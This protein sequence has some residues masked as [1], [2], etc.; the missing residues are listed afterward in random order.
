MV[1]VPAVPG[2]VAQRRPVLE[3]GLP[4]LL[5]SGEG[6]EGCHEH[7][8]GA[9]EVYFEMVETLRPTELGTGQQVKVSCRN[10]YATGTVCNKIQKK[11]ITMHDARMTMDK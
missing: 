6:S 5:C 7:H 3:Q 11:E 4:N 10:G 9:R 2:I 1:A 8:R